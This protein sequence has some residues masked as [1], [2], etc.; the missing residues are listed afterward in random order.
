[1]DILP[2]CV[3]IIWDAIN[4]VGPSYGF[5]EKNSDHFIHLPVYTTYV[6]IG[7]TKGAFLDDPERRLLGS[8]A[9]IRHIKLTRAEDMDD[10]YI[11]DLVRQAVESAVQSREPVEA[12]S[13][14]RVMDGKK[15]RPKQ[16]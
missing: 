8:G 7:F 1:M 6:N 11:R 16:G 10:P 2:P 12:R 9:R 13:L 5:T 14:V 4:T 15:R 3:E